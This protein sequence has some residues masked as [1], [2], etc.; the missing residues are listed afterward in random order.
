MKTVPAMIFLAS[1]FSTAF[2]AAADQRQDCAQKAEGK[3][4]SERARII[5]ACVR[6]NA[7]INTVPPMLARMTECNH[8]AGD[9]EGEQRVR[10]VD[11]CLGEN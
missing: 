11:K 8:K 5:S 2:A 4:G 9:M 3:L 1:C 7:S 6:H 10:F